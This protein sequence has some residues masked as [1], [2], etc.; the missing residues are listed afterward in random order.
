[1]TATSLHR[2]RKAERLA[3]VAS[4]IGVVGSVVLGLMAPH[5]L[6]P[7]WRLA[8]FACLQPA[9]GS[10]IFILIHRLTGGQWGRG[11]APFLLS[12]TRLLPWVWL[13][14][15]P[16]LWF[17]IAAQPQEP[18]VLREE[19]HPAK[20]DKTS[21][22][23]EM[24]EA[25]VHVFA[26]GGSRTTGSR[27]E[28]YFSRPMLVVR[29]VAYAI[30]F[31]LL[32]LGA[33]RAMRATTTMRWFGPV[34][35]IG[36]VFVLHLLATDWFLSLDPGWYSTGFPLVWISAQAI[37]GIALA[38]GAAAAFGANPQRTGRADHIQGLDWGNL[39]LASIMVWSYVAFVQLLII[40]S[41]NLPAETAWYR[42]RAFGVWRGVSIA[43]A[44]IEFGA[45]FF[46]LLSR[47]VKKGRRGLGA[48]TLLLLL[49]QFGYTVWL[50]APAF[51]QASFHA[52]WLLLA[53]CV[54]AL[55]L[56]AN[57]YLAGVRAAAGLLD[58]P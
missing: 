34:G 42:H 36:M 43:V 57:R 6:V 11:L 52:P 20:L 15:I 41:G 26:S 14:I 44:L 21:Q 35:L 53:L 3:L 39:M 32:S 13:L 4:G 12:G 37:A 33:P 1:M 8:A 31:F 54:A 28:W 22:T 51:P 58:A 49:G 7:A 23:Y 17:P 56:F 47:A 50:I 25:L 5:S 38:I 46:L 10:V 24:N 27:L 19:V 45:P 9:L 16:L 30:V 48:V 29:A 18:G 55:G 2:L 40:W